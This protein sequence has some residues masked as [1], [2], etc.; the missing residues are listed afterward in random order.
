MNRLLL[1][2]FIVP[3]F[4]FA[5]VENIAPNYPVLNKT[6][7]VFIDE[8][9]WNKA[10]EEW[11]INYPLEYEALQTLKNGSPQ[12][13]FNYNV[14]NID[15][16]DMVYNP[17]TSDNSYERNPIDINNSN[18]FRLNSVKPV[19]IR[20]EAD[21]DEIKYYFDEVQNEFSKADI[22]IDIEKNLWYI[23]PRNTIYEPSVRIINFKDNLLEA[24]DCSTC[25]PSRL[26][27]IELTETKLVIQIPSK[28]DGEFFNYQFEF[29]R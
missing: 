7:N 14:I 10:I 2:F 13:V 16:K 22:I 27:L 8:Q 4:L 19:E 21:E 9:N 29:I 17:K 28:E 24:F 6:G 26:F 15:D 12:T 18:L 23:F 25:T 3:T 11:K 20:E 5:Q 1:L